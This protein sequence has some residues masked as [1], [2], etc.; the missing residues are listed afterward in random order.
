M[1][2]RTLLARNVREGMQTKNLSNGEWVTVESKIHITSP[3]KVL[4]L[5][6]TDGTRTSLPPSTRVLCRD[7]T[8]S[9]EVN[10]A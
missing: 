3:L 2:E 1:P 10:H 6:F 7:A 5:W 4:T 8:D 9:E